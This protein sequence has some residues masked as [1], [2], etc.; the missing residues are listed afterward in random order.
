MCLGDEDRPRSVPRFD[1]FVRSG[2]R[3]SAGRSGCSW[4]SFLTG[5]SSVN[6]SCGYCG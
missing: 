6:K 2:E 3:R 4:D 5:I 1:G